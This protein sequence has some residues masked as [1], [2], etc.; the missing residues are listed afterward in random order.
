MIKYILD[1]IILKN[2]YGLTLEEL[3]NY[4][5]SI[6]SKKFHA[7]QLF[8]WLYEKRIKNFDEVTDI[9][10]EIIDKLKIDF[11]NNRLKIVS[12]ENDKDVSKYLFELEDGEHIEADRKSVV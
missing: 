9:K 10:K 8:S 5:I 6:G 3:E 11:N 1:V 2:I 7:K 12:I 4:F